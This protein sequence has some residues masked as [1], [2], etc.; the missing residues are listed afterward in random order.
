MDKMG[1]DGYLVID[2]TTKE[3]GPICSEY[4]G[5]LGMNVIRVDHPSAKDMKE[6]D[7]YY[8]VADNLNKRCVTVDY[9]TEEGKKLLFKMISK[10]DVIV[11]NRPFGFMESLGCGW[12][13]VK[14]ANPKLVYCSIKPVSKDSPWANAAWNPTT[15]D[16]LGGATYMTGYVGGIPVEPGPQLSDLSTC[17][18]AAT[19]ILAALYHREDTGKGDYIEA[20]MQDALVA[21]GRSAYEKFA[22]NGIVTRVGNN[23]PTLPDMV[24]MSLFKTKGD[25]PED[26]A[27]IGCFGDEMVKTL[28]EAMGMPEL[29]EDPR[30]DSFDHRL[31]NKQELLDIIQD[32][33]LQH[34]KLDLMEN[35][36]GKKRLVCSAVFTTRDMINS[37]DLKNIGFMHTV[38]DEKLGAMTLPG[39]ASI[40]HSVEPVPVK[41][42]GRPGTAN[43]EVFKE[44]DI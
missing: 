5:L 15:I 30:F 17:G 32:F 19:A 3:A 6:S 36:L 40:F 4:L 34:N 10:A 8:F 43:E 2:F 25:G 14:E 18:Y 11:E 28:F 31:D 42:P 13:Q 35:L 26:W 33:A 7:Q 9:D 29:Y 44:L 27:M 39:C 22:I 37:E 21:H 12:E 16:A 24:P 20:S 1:L 41:A 38:E 23:F